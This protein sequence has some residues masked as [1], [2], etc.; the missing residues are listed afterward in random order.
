MGE[1]VFAGAE[2]RLVVDKQRARAFAE[3]LRAE[4]P[5]LLER[6]DAGDGAIE[7]PAEQKKPVT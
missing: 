3:F 4:L 5:A 2:V 7:H 1:A 6:F